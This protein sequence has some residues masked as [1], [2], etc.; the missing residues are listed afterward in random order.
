MNLKNHHAEKN[1]FYRPKGKKNSSKFLLVC[2]LFCF[3]PF[4]LS[5]VLSLKYEGESTCG[6]KEVN[7]IGERRDNDKDTV[8]SYV[9]FPWSG[10][11]KKAD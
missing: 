6:R 3:S 9:E 10:Q 1:S 7:G 4:P 8:L 5:S 2:F 11:K